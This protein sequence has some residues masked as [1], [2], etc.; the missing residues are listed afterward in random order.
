MYK[1]TSRLCS[2]QMHFI[3]NE[4][5]FIRGEMTSSSPDL[6]QLVLA[7]SI[8]LDAN[9]DFLCLE[10]VKKSNLNDSAEDS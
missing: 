4:K 2:V 5:K 10:S 6:Q 8:H 3:W 7:N 1:L 9:P